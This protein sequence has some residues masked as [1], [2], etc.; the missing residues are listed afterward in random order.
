MIYTVI[1]G[2][3]L[4]VV[5]YTENSLDSFQRRPEHSI[6]NWVLFNESKM[7][8][9]TETGDQDTVESTIDGQTVDKST[10]T[11]SFWRIISR[12]GKQ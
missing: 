2:N 8:M 6:N 9:S 1:R 12:A 3:T 4:G 5:L 11:L 7:R 10:K